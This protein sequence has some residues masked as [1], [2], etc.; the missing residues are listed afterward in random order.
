MDASD[1]IKDKKQDEK[2][3][4][5]ICENEKRP[6]KGRLFPIQSVLFYFLLTSLMYSSRAIVMEG[7]PG[8][9]A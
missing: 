1:K 7:V 8:L 4:N 3:I 5:M 6:A 2:A 9:G